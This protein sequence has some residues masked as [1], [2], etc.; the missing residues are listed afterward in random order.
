M[1]IADSDGIEGDEQRVAMGNSLGLR[2]P[3]CRWVRV[4][5]YVVRSAVR[6]T[7]IVMTETEA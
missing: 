4:A 2:W 6:Q 7:L 5:A 3:W 1:R